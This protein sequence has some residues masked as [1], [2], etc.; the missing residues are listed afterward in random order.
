MNARLPLLEGS[1]SAELLPAPATRGQFHEIGRKDLFERCPPGVRKEDWSSFR[2]DY[3]RADGL[4]YMPNPVQLDIEL[5]GGCNMAC[6]FCVHGYEDRPNAGMSFDAYKSI[7]KQAVTF[8]VK[9]L[10]LNYL[11]EPMLR[12]DLEKFIRYAKDS[13][14]LNIYMS[15]NGTLLN[16]KRNESILDSGITKIFISV[17]AATPETYNKQRLSGKFRLVVDNVLEFMRA[18]EARGLT[19]PIVRVSFLRNSLNRHEEKDFLDF[20]NPKVDMVVVQ[21]MNELPDIDSG[22]AYVG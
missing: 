1:L 20:W 11:N 19:Y 7:I 4:E 8:G 14:I 6:P 9:S 22:L 2:E 3:N 13:G 15:T 18:R 12:K 17:D 10:K 21:R 5:N 16:H